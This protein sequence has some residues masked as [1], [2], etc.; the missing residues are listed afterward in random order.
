[1]IYRLLEG[2]EPR[3]DFPAIPIFQELLREK[4]LLIAEHTRRHLREEIT[5]PGPVIDR[6]S[7]ARWVKKG[8]LTLKGGNAVGLVFR[9]NDTGSQSYDA[10]IDIVDGVFKIS[11]RSPYKV[12]GRYTFTPQY[13]TPY[14]VKVVAHGNTL[15]GYLDGV[16]RISV[17]DGTLTSGKFGVIV[18]RATAEFDDLVATR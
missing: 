2:I 5:F 9:S 16:K 10:I 8:K 1:M 12:L 6:G 7:R 3:E 18:F 14:D 11:K 13:D 4:H 17:I 15:E